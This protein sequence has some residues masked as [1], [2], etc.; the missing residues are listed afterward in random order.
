VAEGVTN[1]MLEGEVLRTTHPL[2]LRTQRPIIIHN[3]SVIYYGIDLAI[4]YKCSFYQIV[5]SVDAP[6]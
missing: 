3:P 6:R 4:N 5:W 2:A 1:K